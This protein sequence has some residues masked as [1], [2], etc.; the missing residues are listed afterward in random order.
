M[1]PLHLRYHV[2]SLETRL[3]ASRTSHPRIA[4]FDLDNTL[5]IGD[6]GEAVFAQLLVD[7]VRLGRTWSEYE[8]LLRY[9]QAAACKLVVEAMAGLSVREVNRVTL[10]VL[11]DPTPYISIEDACVPVPKPHRLMREL[12]YFLQRLGYSSYIISAS[13]QISVRIVSSMFFEIPE[14][15]VFGMVSKTID[16]V[17]TP[18]LV[19]PY[20]VS[21]GK[22]E[23][24]RKF[25]HSCPPLITASDSIVDAPM[26]GLTDPMGLSIWVGKSRGSYRAM[27]E[28]L[29]HPQ[30]SCFVQRPK[31]Q[32]FRKSV[33]VLEEQEITAPLFSSFLT[34]T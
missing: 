3:R 15:H 33:R 6:I 5:I 13:N 28:R 16:G 23:V 8:G 7:G 24:Y 9:D 18:T 17:L 12:I 20:P 29:C 11:N 14:S 19:E 31:Y 10:K 25:I 30:R 22:V 32:S 27:K 2:E 1:I 26:L 21:A 4:L 34:E